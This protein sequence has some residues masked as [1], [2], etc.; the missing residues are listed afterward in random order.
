MI[1]EGISIYDFL[2]F[3][4]SQYRQLMAHKP[5]RIA[6][7][8]EKHLSIISVFS[9]ALSK[10]EDG[11]DA[12][13]LLSLFSCFGP[14]LI[15]LDLL[16]GFWKSKTIIEEPVH[17]DVSSLS[18]K[19][20]WLKTVGDNRLPFQQATAR[21]ENLCLLKTRRDDR[22]NMMSVSVHSTVCKWRLETIDEQEREDYIMLAALILSYDLPDIGLDT[23]PRLGHIPL[24]KHSHDLMQQYI[25]PRSLE[26][27]DGIGGRL[28]QHY[29]TVVARYA[30]VYTQS[31]YA[32][33]AEAMLTATIK[34][35]KLLQGSSWPQDRRSLFLSKYLALSL[36]KTGKSDDAVPVLES[37]CTAN[38]E[39][40]GD[41]DNIP[42]WAAAQLRDVREREILCGRLQQQAVI[43]SNG[44]KIPSRLERVSVD[45]QFYAIAENIPTPL[46]DKEY[47][48]VQTVVETES[49]LGPTDDDTLLAI[50]DLAQFYENS[51]SYFKAG[52][53]YENLWRR[54]C[55]KYDQ[56]RGPRA[57]ADAVHCYERSGRLT[58]K[59]QF[60]PLSDCLV[61]AASY[62]DEKSVTTLIMAGAKID[63]TDRDSQTALYL[64]ARNHNDKLAR[65]LLE[66][67]ANTEIRSSFGLTA[68]HVV[69]DWRDYKLSLEAQP[70]ELQ[71]THMLIEA[72]AN[73]DAITNSGRSV[74]WMAARAGSKDPVQILLDMGIN[75]HISNGDYDRTALQAAS[76][77]G[78]EEVVKLLLESGIYK[79][80]EGSCCV[81]ALEG[82]SE[83][84]QIAVVRLLLA[85]KIDYTS[86]Y[87]RLS[88]V[89][90]TQHTKVIEV[91]FAFF[92]DFDTP[93]D[94]KTGA[95]R[96][97][98][99]RAVLCAIL[100]TGNELLLGPLCERGIDL[101][102]S[103]YFI[104]F[105]SSLLNNASHQ[106]HLKVAETLIGL[107]VDTNKLDDFGC[108]P[109]SLA[110]EFG[111]EDI[112]ALLLPVTKVIN[113]QDILG[114][115]ALGLA[116]ERREKKMVEMLLKA[117][118]QIAPQE[119]GPP[120]LLERERMTGY[121][122]DAILTLCWDQRPLRPSVLE[123]R[124]LELLLR[125]AI[126][127]RS[128][129]GLDV[130]ITTAEPLSDTNVEAP[131]Q[132]ISHTVLPDHHGIDTCK[133]ALE[134]LREEDW[135]RWDNWVLARATSAP[136]N[137]GEATKLRSLMKK[138]HTD[139]FNE[140][141]NN[142][143]LKRREELKRLLPES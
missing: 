7:D 130:A 108:S 95:E 50:T 78:H 29:A 59:L 77:G 35:E 140:I 23:V 103:T 126:T 90:A 19:I 133:E 74:L 34:C 70:Q 4:G 84:G 22:G 100:D 5:S 87:E 17:F 16:T 9:M 57:L 41:T 49:L 45:E 67:D 69:F 8:Y 2:D 86:D 97:L 119:P 122:N 15:P 127:E 38:T 96:D 1:G 134:I 36:L 75:D 102:Q 101:N 93:G 28:C 43:A 106:G 113:A 20:Q 132:A 42:I 120:C 54:Y 14:R 143:P 32:S 65:R 68:L 92:I 80:A 83:G 114:D 60:D 62:G 71:I 24:I 30:Q 139:R 18:K 110:A 118:A 25:D 73:V 117:G 48:L 56:H 85:R 89:F 138:R 39:P 46:S 115:T 64:A 125:A 131:S 31:I 52:T 79:H 135:G 128:Q 61:W 124:L 82:A 6:S 63:E 66:A 98:A 3:Y 137:R 81:A 21:L 51:A 121:A 129:S 76:Y 26:A 37:L 88:K 116:V 44:T 12:P 47:S 27:V 111:H 58:E 55:S 123:I 107:G 136:Q 11:R 72:G 105:H 99:L 53:S 33:Q 40:L 104:S 94:P 109:L 91:L 10:L 112:V 142:I 141:K 13:D